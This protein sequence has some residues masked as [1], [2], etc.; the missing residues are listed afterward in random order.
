MDAIHLVLAYGALAATIVGVAWS[1]LR[2]ARGRPEASGFVRFQAAA[3]SLI[4]VGAA[5]G[6]LMF[7]AGARPAEGLHLLYSA[8]AVAIIPLARSFV[9]RTSSRGAALL[10]FVAFV[11]LTAVTYRLFTT[12]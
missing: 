11:V 10:F 5:S 4:I 12:G 8:I 1:L 2:L 6:V 9:G 3:V 7:L